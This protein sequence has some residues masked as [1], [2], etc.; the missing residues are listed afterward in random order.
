M[1]A[2]TTHHHA[3]DCREKAIIKAL[4]VAQDTMEAYANSF[5]LEEWHCRVED[6]I[7]T[8]YPRDLAPPRIGFVNPPEPEPAT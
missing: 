5:D 7:G 1:S 8:K 2:C 6:L 4:A 3:C